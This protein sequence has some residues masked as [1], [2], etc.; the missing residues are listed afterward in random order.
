MA[1]LSKNNFDKLWKNLST[2]YSNSSTHFSQ[3][4]ATT[5]PSNNNDNNNNTSDS[6]NNIYND[7][8][9][10]SATFALILPFC[11]RKIRWKM[12]PV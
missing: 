9:D 1:I 6:N 5:A 12:F 10:D 2:I 3:P 8:D 4:S 7:D 11:Q